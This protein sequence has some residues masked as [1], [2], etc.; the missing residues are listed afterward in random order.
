MVGKL[1]FDLTRTHPN[2]C[3]NCSKLP[4]TYAEIPQSIKPA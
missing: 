3:Q 2:F 1:K 4:A